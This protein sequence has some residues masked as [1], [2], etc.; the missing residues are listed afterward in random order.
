[1][2]LCFGAST[3]CI[4]KK[5]KKGKKTLLIQ[6][7][8]ISEVTVHCCL[9]LQSFSTAYIIKNKVLAVRNECASYLAERSLDI[10]FKIRNN[11]IFSTYGIV[12]MLSQ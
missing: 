6:K 8:C 9:L 12:I 4:G 11:E 10:V 3:L 1:M 5:E 2:V 7:H